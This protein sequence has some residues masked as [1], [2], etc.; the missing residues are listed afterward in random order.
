[1]ACA[2][3]AGSPGRSWTSRNAWHPM[4][5]TIQSPWLLRSARRL[6]ALNTSGATRPGA[7]ARQRAG[8]ACS[9][10]ASSA[11]ARA[12]PVRR[13]TARFAAHRKIR[14]RPSRRSARPRSVAPRL[15][16]RVPLGPKCA[17]ARCRAHSQR[18]HAVP[19]STPLPQAQ[20]KLPSVVAA[21][22]PLRL[23]APKR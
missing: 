8:Q 13:S 18:P 4:G 14:R 5:G 2:D 1:V 19:Y 11:S 7:R 6:L 15:S 23:S 21:A 20:F 16:S 12:L 17:C 22:M 3:T 9:C 10:A